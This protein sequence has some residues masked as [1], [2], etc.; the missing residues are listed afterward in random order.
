MSTIELPP[1]YTAAFA[2]AHSLPLYTE[3]P[4]PAECTLHSTVSSSAASTSSHELAR[5][6]VFAT[7]HLEIDL[8]EFPS[9]LLHPAY[10]YNGV[11]EGIVKFRSK[12]T[13]VLQ[14]T[15]KVLWTHCYH[16]I[17]C[18][19]ADSPTSTA[20]GHR[21]H[22]GVRTRECYHCWLSFYYAVLANS[23]SCCRAQRWCCP[24]NKRRQHLSLCYRVSNV[25]H[26][27][28]L[29]SSTLIHY[30]TRRGLVRNQI[31]HPS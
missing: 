12:C 4:S 20:R 31:L 23:P 17:M 22:N 11:V 30:N 8:G 14:V 28:E 3:S 26:G 1:H 7:D 5:R 27:T 21:S 9:A 25:H 2:H 19:A 6:F 16:S 29:V 15:V 10:G 13:H 18:V 24:V